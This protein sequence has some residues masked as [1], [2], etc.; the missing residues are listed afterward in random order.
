MQASQSITRPF[1]YAACL[2]LQGNFMSIRKPTP[3]VAVSLIRAAFAEAVETQAPLSTK[4]AYDLL[5]R[6]NGF[7][8]WAHAKATLNSASTALDVPKKSVY[9]PE[10]IQDWSTFVVFSDYDET[11]DEVHF[12]L[13]PGATLKNRANP[14]N[15]WE[16]F[17]D[18]GRIPMPK[19]FEAVPA[20]ERNVLLAKSFVVK[21]I[22]SAIP[23][24]ERYGVPYYANEL[25][26][27][28]WVV[29]ELGWSVVGQPE[30]SYANGY[31]LMEINFIDS[32]D[33]SGG[34]YW[35]EVS[36]PSAVAAVLKEAFA[37][38]APEE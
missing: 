14:R 18:T 34:R 15:S 5:A 33:D 25:G 9:T 32:G 36:V 6:V 13:P 4:Q 29:D 28:D 38:F 10:E 16:P 26:A 12:V 30:T 27:M 37:A 21:E 3:K 31:S 20:D 8:N 7:K 22:F 1:H 23:R 11:G 35:M 24:P 2:Q 19:F 17:D